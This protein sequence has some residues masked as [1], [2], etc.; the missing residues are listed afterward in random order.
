MKT[1]A[2]VTPIKTSGFVI[3]TSV[4]IPL[5]TSK[6][7]SVAALRALSVAS[8]GASLLIPPGTYKRDVN[9][10]LAARYVGGSGWYA[11]RAVEGG[12]RIWKIAEPRVRT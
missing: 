11:I 9:L 1:V 4:P 8:V 6:S 2:T 12:Q 5:P 7:P 10:G 3:E